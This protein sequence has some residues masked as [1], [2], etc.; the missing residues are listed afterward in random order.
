[1]SRADDGPTSSPQSLSPARSRGA[2]E[3]VSALRNGCAPRTRCTGIRSCTPGS[4]RGTT[5]WSRCSTDFSAERT[6]IAGAARRAWGC[7][8]LGPDRPGHGQADAV[9]RPARA[10]AHSTAG[11]GGVHAHGAW[12]LLR[13]HIQEIADALHRRRACRRA[14]M[15]VIADLAEPL[16]GDRDGRDARR[17]GRG[18]PQAQGL[19]AGLRRDA[20]Q[21]SAQS[22]PR[23]PAS[24][25][26]VE[27]MTAYFREAIARAARRSP[28]GARPRADDRGGRRR[29]ADR[30]R[31]RRQRASSPWSA[32]RRRPPT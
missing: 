22:R 1:M 32:A 29:P 10:H 3:S 13:D 14:R 24:L 11:L 9:P 19:V 16:P 5:T 23:A 28:E 7:R 27:E 30:R 15:D 26:S 18:P 17:A 31:D 2:G 25:R 21:L 4:S 8:A 20:R 6:P 12:R